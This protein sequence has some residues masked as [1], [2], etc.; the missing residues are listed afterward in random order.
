MGM[1]LDTIMQT[2]VVYFDLS[3]YYFLSLLA[4][5]GFTGGSS[6]ASSMIFAI[7]ADTTPNRWLGVRM[8]VL[9]ATMTFG[10]AVA[11]IGTNNWIQSTNCNFLYPSLLNVGTALCAVVFL[12]LMRESFSPQEQNAYF[13]LRR[14]ILAIFNGL[15]IFFNPY[16]LGFSNWWRAWTATGVICAAAACSVGGTEILNFF[17]HNR[18]LQW[19][20]DKIGYFGAFIF[21]FNGLV[22]I[23]A[24]PMLIAVRFSY[25]L[26]GLIGA[27][28]G[29]IAN[30]MVALVKC[31]WEMYVGKRRFWH[32]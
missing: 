23:T 14:V 15:R 25:P 11:F 2:L 5:H 12:F 32:S 26:V 20:Y 30:V 19:S 27:V 28:C 29:I 22:L 1:S 17:L 3:T 8:S 21:G 7:V 13:S 4:I 10:K 31:N 6:L 18:P 16:Y 9:E 24:V